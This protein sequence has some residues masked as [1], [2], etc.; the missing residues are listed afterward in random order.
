MAGDRSVYWP[1]W[2][3]L[4]KRAFELRQQRD[5]PAQVRGADGRQRFYLSELA[6]LVLDERLNEPVF[7]LAPVLSAHYVGVAPETWES[8]LAGRFHVLQEQLAYWVSD[9]MA[10]IQPR[11]MDEGSA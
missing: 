3:Q 5:W 6:A 7:R 9:A 8:A 1:L 2:E 11:L 10:I 4:A